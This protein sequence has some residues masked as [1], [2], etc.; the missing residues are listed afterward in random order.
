MTGVRPDSC[1]AVAKAAATR[2][3]LPSPSTTT[4]CASVGLAGATESSTTLRPI[5]RV[6]QS[7]PD[8]ASGCGAPFPHR[9]A[10]VYQQLMSE[11]PAE[12]RD[13]NRRG[14]VS[15]LTFSAWLLGSPA[16]VLHLPTSG[17]ATQSRIAAVNFSSCVERENERATGS[18]SRAV[19]FAAGT[20]AH[21][22]PPKTF[23]C[24][25]KHSEHRRFGVRH[26]AIDS[27][28]RPADRNR[29][30]TGACL[31]A[32]RLVGGAQ[33]QPLSGGSSIFVLLNLVSLTDT[34]QSYRAI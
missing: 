24:V 26:R 5:H 25:R 3:G 8:L 32:R 11:L 12:K 33:P 27:S 31:H 16:R 14:P 6:V 28:W 7:C 21:A 15:I 18:E 22:Y 4:R 13:E 1:V 2:S 9:C 17:V 34:A 23:R 19:Y 20:R 10:R 29:P 30:G